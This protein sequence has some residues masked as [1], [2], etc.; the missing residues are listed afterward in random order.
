MLYSTLI[1]ILLGYLSFKNTKIKDPRFKEEGQSSARLAAAIIVSYLVLV[2]LVLTSMDPKYHWFPRH[3]QMF[4]SLTIYANVS[5]VVFF[6]VIFIP[7]V[8]GYILYLL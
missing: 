4:W 8:S 3:V 2:I 1:L 7:K 6:S 5:P